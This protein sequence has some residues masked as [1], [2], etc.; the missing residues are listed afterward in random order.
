MLHYI[1]SRLKS[2]L[3]WIAIALFVL[4]TI[5]PFIAITSIILVFAVL[6]PRSMAYIQREIRVFQRTTQGGEE[7]KGE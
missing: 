6:N 7:E 3:F 2:R 1:T 5:S 4:D